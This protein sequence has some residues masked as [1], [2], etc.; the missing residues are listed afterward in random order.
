MLPFPNTIYRHF[1]GGYYLVLSVSTD[2][3]DT[4]KNYV[5]YVSLNG[6]NKIWSRPLEEFIGPVP[7]NRENPTGQADR[8]ER[9]EN[10]GNFVSSISTDNLVAELRSRRESPLNDVDLE[11]FNEYVKYRD[12]VVGELNVDGYV[13]PIV[14]VDSLDSAE[15]WCEKHFD[16]CSSRSKIYKR[17]YVEI[18]SFD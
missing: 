13:V 5:N 11:S 4:S 12:Y 17:V 14:C 18:E 1:K 3:N 9:V 8:F 16:K 15:K 2:C 6:D 10:I 7:L